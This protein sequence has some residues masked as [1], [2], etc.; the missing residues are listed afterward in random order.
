M[1]ER[2]HQ[3]AFARTLCTGQ[4]PG[5]RL[6]GRRLG[7]LRQQP[8][9]RR[10]E[11]RGR[12]RRW[13]PV[14]P[15]G[16]LRGVRTRPSRS[17]TP[18]RSARNE[19]TR[20]RRPAASVSPC[21]WASLTPKCVASFEA[22]ATTERR[23]FPPTNT[24]LPCSVGS[25]SCSTWA[26][27]ESMSACTNHLDPIAAPVLMAGTA[28]LCT[29]PARTADNR[30]VPAR[31]GRSPASDGTSAPDRGGLRSSDRGRRASHGAN[32]SLTTP[33][34]RAAKRA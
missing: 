31:R 10:S 29:F 6:G 19:A 20:R 15:C 23:P 17:A 12:P 34:S 26:N 28:C 30:G 27:M 16:R 21:P 25:S 24:G 7:S 9:D 5:P 8:P 33:A 14:R 11:R 1:R 3:S 32:T 2:L 4:S 13:R 22:A 18:R